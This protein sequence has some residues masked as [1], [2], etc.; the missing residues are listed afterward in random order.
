MVKKKIID[1]LPKIDQSEN[2]VSKPCQQGK[3]LRINH[4]QTLKILTNGPLELFHMDLMGPSRM[5]SLGG[6]RYILVVVDDFSR[7]TWIEL[8]REKSE[9]GDLVKSL[10][11]RLKIEQN[12]SI[13]RV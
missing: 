5:E 10:C 4:K 7:Y 12:L 2:V 6:K 9:T 13:S 1:G 8:L 3:Q 11:K